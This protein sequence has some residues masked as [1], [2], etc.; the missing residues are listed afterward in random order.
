[1]GSGQCLRHL[2][3]SLQAGWDA[4]WVLPQGWEPDSTSHQALFSYSELHQ[5]LRYG[6]RPGSLWESGEAGQVG[7][8]SS[9][10]SGAGEGVLGCVAR[11]SVSTCGQLAPGPQL[12]KAVPSLPPAE[13]GWTVTTA[14]IWPEGKAFLSKMGEPQLELSQQKQTGALPLG[15][16]TPSAHRAGWAAPVWEGLRA[17][18]R[19]GPLQAGEGV[20]STQALCGQSG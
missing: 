10:L 6:W 4:S 9:D 16:H 19:Q 11:Q 5:P 3:P 2:G 17:C 7:R 14:S 18:C 12:P 20:S 13:A 8:A 1:M 15:S